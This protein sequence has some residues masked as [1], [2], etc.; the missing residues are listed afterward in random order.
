MAY[1]LCDRS[2]IHEETAISS[3]KNES[4]FETWM[5]GWM[6]GSEDVMPI[7]KD[8]DFGGVWMR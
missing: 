3:L 6:C 1:S 8:K 2:K 7:R 5:E 4:M